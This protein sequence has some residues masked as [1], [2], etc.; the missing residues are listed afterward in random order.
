METT[1][2][3]AT[4]TA[5]AFQQLVYDTMLAAF[6]ADYPGGASSEDPDSPASITKLE[7]VEIVDRLAHEAFDLILH[8]HGD[9]GMYEHPIYD[10]FVGAC[11]V[12]LDATVRALSDFRGR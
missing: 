1:I 3:N 9:D 4:P 11:S 12:A 8:P 2:I 5:A 6:R 10:A 7:A